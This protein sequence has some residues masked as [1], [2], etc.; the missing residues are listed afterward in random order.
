MEKIQNPLLLFCSSESSTDVNSRDRQMQGLQSQLNSLKGHL[1][2]AVNSR[3]AY[4]QE[5][6][7]LKGDLS[8]MTQENQVEFFL[9][10][11]VL[12]FLHI[13]HKAVHEELRNAV[14]EREALRRRLQEQIQ[15]VVNYEEAVASKVMLSLCDFTIAQTLLVGARERR[16]TDFLP[17]NG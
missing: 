17:S 5:I 6:Q 4:E 12:L 16:F 8:T 9:Q 2:D 15:A 11:H 14:E 13:Y 3:E 10:A 1:K 7:R